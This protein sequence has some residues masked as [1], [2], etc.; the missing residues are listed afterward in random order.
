MDEPL[1]PERFT[2]LLRRCYMASDEQLLA[3]FQRSLPFQDALFDRWERA[4]RLG[5]GKGASIY[6]SSFVYGNVRVGDQTWIGPNTVLDGS[7]GNLS[8]GAYCSISAGVHIYTHDTVLWALSRGEV[9]KREANVSIGDCVYI[10][11][12]TVI[13]AGVSIG[14]NSVIAANSFVN[15]DVP[16]RSVV[17]GTPTRR[18]GVVIGQGSGVYIKYDSGT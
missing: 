3:D 4:R 8:I 18:L 11:S 15:G 12:Q 16:E 17:G 5:F 9:S 2:E 7:G 6:N 10:G 13:A 14:K 1:T